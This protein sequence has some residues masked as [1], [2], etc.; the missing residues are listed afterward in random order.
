M[1]HT[2]H[3]KMPANMLLYMGLIALT[4]GILSIAVP[5]FTLKTII[6]S[7][8][9]IIGLSGLTTLI[10]KLIHKSKKRFMQIL[11]I[12]GSIF[13]LL[14]GI[15]LTIYPTKFIEI[16]IIVLGVAIILGGI[17]Q[18]VLSL[19]YTPLTNTAKVFLAFSILMIIA[20]TIMALNPFNAIKGITIFFGIVMTVFGLLN[21]MMSFWLRT[22]ISNFNKLEQ[23]EKPTIIEIEAETTE[24]HNEPK[25]DKEAEK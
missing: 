24:I 14:F 4:F 19:S 3:S 7:I 6:L 17:S 21:V 13:I 12:I 25:E 10:I 18:L 5:E 11:C 8:G 1:R 22:E 20:G 15:A 9:I 2:T 16:F 23:E